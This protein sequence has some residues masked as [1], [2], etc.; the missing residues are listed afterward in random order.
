MG[1]EESRWQISPQSSYRL[2]VFVKILVIPCRK[3]YGGGEEM[4]GAS[5]LAS[6]ILQGYE[7]TTLSEEYSSDLIFNWN[8]EPHKRIM[9]NINHLAINPV[10]QSCQLWTNLHLVSNLWFHLFCFYCFYGAKIQSISDSSKFL[11]FFLMMITLIMFL[12]VSGTDIR[13]CRTLEDTRDRQVSCSDGRCLMSEGWCS[14]ANLPRNKNDITEFQSALYM[15]ARKFSRE[16][17]SL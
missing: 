3:W 17:L 5:P 8:D 10:W 1:K 12:T 16:L 15:I 9:F 7:E 6:S 11:F 4:A 13:G 2:R 14:R